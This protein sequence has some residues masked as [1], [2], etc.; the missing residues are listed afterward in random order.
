MISSSPR[1]SGQRPRLKMT[2]SLTRGSTK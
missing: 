2:Q 1:A